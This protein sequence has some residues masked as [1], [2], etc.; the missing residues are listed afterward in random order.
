M[1][2]VLG[3]FLLQ[4]S[5][6][7]SPMVVRWLA[8]SL[9][10]LFPCPRFLFACP[11]AWSPLASLALPLRVCLCVGVHIMCIVHKLVLVFVRVRERLHSIFRVCVHLRVHAFCLVCSSCTR[12]RLC[13]ASERLLLA[14]SLTFF[15]VRY[16]SLRVRACSPLASLSRLLRVCLCV[17]VHIMCMCGCVHMLVLVCVRGLQRTLGLV[18]VRVRKPLHAIICV[19]VHLRVHTFFC[20]C[21]IV[22]A[23]VFAYLCVCTRVCMYV[24]LSVVVCM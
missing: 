23:F 20:S 11:L 15:I 8:R 6:C 10:H 7:V 17:C 2:G 4:S 21:R 12:P 3:L 19:C 16:S 18:F 1:A 5:S 14:R 24:C 22:G 13:L 9:A